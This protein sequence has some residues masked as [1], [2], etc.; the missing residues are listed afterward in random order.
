MGAPGAME[1]SRRRE[2]ALWNKFPGRDGLPDG[3][4][5]SVELL[6]MSK[7][8]YKCIVCDR[9]EGLVYYISAP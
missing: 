6:L 4:F 8:P 1:I 7:S 2:I 9:P 3:C 5:R